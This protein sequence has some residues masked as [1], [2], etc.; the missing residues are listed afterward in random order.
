MKESSGMVIF[1]T[2]FVNDL[3]LLCFDIA[4][5]LPSHLCAGLLGDP[6]C[7]WATNEG[8]NGDGAA[9]PIFPFNTPT[10]GGL[11]FLPFA[12][13]AA[14]ELDAQQY[15]QQYC[16]L[17]NSPR[18]V[19]LGQAQLIPGLSPRT[20][21][22]GYMGD[23]A[24]SFKLF[25]S[26][27]AVVVGQQQEQGLLHQKLASS[28]GPLLVRTTGKAKAEGGQ[29]LEGR[30]A[31]ASSPMGGAC[32]LLDRADGAVHCLVTPVRT[33][34]GSNSRPSSA[35]GR[36]QG[37]GLVIEA[38]VGATPPAAKPVFE[39]PLSQPR[40][41]STSPMKRRESSRSPLSS[42]SPPTSPVAAAVDAQDASRQAAYE[43]IL[44]RKKGAASATGPPAAPTKSAAPPAAI[45]GPGHPFAQMSAA[46]SLG[47][48]DLM[49]EPDGALM[50]SLVREQQQLS[51]TPMLTWCGHQM[52][53]PSP[54]SAQRDASAT[55]SQGS[56]IGGKSSPVA[57]KRL[58]PGVVT[59]SP[60]PSRNPE[61]RAKKAKPAPSSSGSR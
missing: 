3:P 8:G 31:T 55:C 29:E 40:Q 20:C 48:R 46:A 10:A 15:A 39:A 2:A 16:S 9:G 50:A 22:Q 51:A 19:A 17:L 26:P 27:A 5:T 4:T 21:G 60:S 6:S 59:L 61:R 49:T 25:N 12:S 43:Y 41:P 53:A 44:G 11:A 47:C 14:G 54:R 56:Q 32:A 36:P 33:Q 52:S 24:S 18:P 42:R 37:R 34:Q 35:A 1:T 30:D 38:S 45:P 13:A 58:G 23:E 28:L 7:L 57:Q